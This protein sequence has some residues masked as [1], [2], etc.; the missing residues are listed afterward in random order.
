MISTLLPI[1]LSGGTGTRLWPLSREAAPKPFMPLPDGET[2]L[3]KTAAR[4]FA[5]AGIDTLVTITN[6]DYYFHT[7][8]TYSAMEMPETTTAIYMLEPFGRNTAPAIAVGALLAQSRGWGQHTLLV[9]PADHLI[10][11]Q[12]AFADAVFGYIECGDTLVPQEGSAP[13]A[14]RAR[15]FVEKPAMALAREYLAAGHYVWNSG[16]FAFTA[17]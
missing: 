17:D 11:D 8:D 2:L 16:L 1:I 6:R 13:A 5:L 14:Y 12:R 15:R 10:R 7:K 9:M 4:A 3:G